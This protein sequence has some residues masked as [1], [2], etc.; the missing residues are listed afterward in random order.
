VTL[1]ESRIASLPED[2]IPAE[3]SSTMRHSKD[4]GVIDEESS[5]YVPGEIHCEDDDGIVKFVFF[6]ER[7][8][9]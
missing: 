2:A 4:T 3:I 7:N 9:R 5:P 6:T 8:A 1:D